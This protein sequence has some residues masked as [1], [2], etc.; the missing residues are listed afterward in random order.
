MPIVRLLFVFASLLLSSVSISW[1]ENIRNPQDAAIGAE[2]HPKILAEFGGELDDPQIVQYVRNLGAN[3][4]TNSE[5]PYE[6]WTFTVLDTPIV[7]AF[8]TPG[9]YVYVTR[10]LLALANDEAELAAVL[11]HEISHITA[12][13][14]GDREGEGKDALRTGLLGA[15]MGG[16]FPDGEDRLGSAIKS[17]IMATVG[18]MSQFSQQQEFEADRLGIEI[19][20][21]A[22]YDP[23]AQ[24]DFLDHLSEKHALESQIAGKEYNPNSVDFFASHPA[25][26][27][28][29]REAIAEAERNGLSS[30]RFPRNQT[31]YL[32]VIEGLVYGDALEQGLVRGQAFFHPDFRFAFKVPE[33]FV[34]TNTSQAVRAKG[35]N[36]SSMVLTGDRAPNGTLKD[37]ISGKWARQI[38]SQTRSGVLE[39]LQ[40]LEINGLEAATAVLPIQGRAGPINLRLTVIRMGNTV[41][42]ISGGSHPDDDQIAGEIYAAMQTFKQMEDW[43]AALLSPYTIATYSVEAGDTVASLSSKLP[44]D[45]FQEQRFRTLNG[46][47]ENEEISHGDL[48]KMIVE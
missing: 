40:D 14:M 13:H 38:A 18:H 36:F 17:G 30:Q 6:E 43:E 19:L 7:N 25:T 37:Y 31:G 5:Q 16:I 39:G 26:A 2:N 46:L 32:A 41:Y 20:V 47:D 44:F 11:A 48:V 23:Y 12:D 45:T 24:A 35:P 4:V 10:G 34:I 29:V 27:E 28:R 8:A 15:I 33:N 42:R 22:G 9:G 21:A 3:L 1:A